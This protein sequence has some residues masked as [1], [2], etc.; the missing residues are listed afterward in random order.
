MSEESPFSEERLAE[1]LIKYYSMGLMDNEVQE[2]ASYYR[3]VPEIGLL[4]QRLDDKELVDEHLTHLD[5]AET[6]KNWAITVSQLQAPSV[7]VKANR[8]I[9][10]WSLSFAAA[11]LFII[12]ISILSKVTKP[13]K[14]KD[15]P[16]VSSGKGLTPGHEKAVLILSDGQEIELDSTTMGKVVNLEGGRITQTG[17]GHLDFALVA[18]SANQG[19]GNTDSIRYNTLQTPRGGQFSIR[20]PDGTEVLLNNVTSLYIPVRFT[21]MGRKV[22]LEGEAYFDVAN[23]DQQAFSVISKTGGKE[24]T[25]NVLGTSFNI[26]AY[27]DEAIMRT[28]LVK[29]K[30]KITSGNRTEI[31]MPKEQ[32]V[33]SGDSLIHRKGV[34]MATALAWKEGNF[35]FSGDSLPGVLRQIARWYDKEVVF[36][37]LLSPHEFESVLP[38]SPLP[39]LLD[40]LSDQ[41]KLFHYALE[42]NKIFISQ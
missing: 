31:L 13:D 38:R 8:S 20:L 11:V 33:I 21:R 35:N 4:L 42:G 6:E 16:A 24:Q 34:K 15:I 17:A 30:I 3:Q 32:L 12:F 28:T 22:K 37:G 18:G 40:R 27:S 10:R 29:G 26:C 5:A 25:V 41:N 23:N 14:E 36:L 19:Q 9:I 2:L 39:D 1:L 7:P